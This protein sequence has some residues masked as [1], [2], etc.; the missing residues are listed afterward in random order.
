MSDVKSLYYRPKGAR[1]SAALLSRARAILRSRRA[2]GP[3]PVL[4]PA[5]GPL[6]AFARGSRGLKRKRG[7]M[8]QM[9]RN[10]KKTRNGGKGYTRQFSR[11]VKQVMNYE[12][13]S[14]ASY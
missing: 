8:T 11:N 12:N 3:R 9:K 6:A 4:P 2:G 10:R 7:V 5:P 13:N 1:M 14:P